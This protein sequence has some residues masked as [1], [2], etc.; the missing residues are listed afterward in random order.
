MTLI[1][2]KFSR[3]HNYIKVD[4]GEPYFWLLR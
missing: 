2:L 3:D 1:N 4:F